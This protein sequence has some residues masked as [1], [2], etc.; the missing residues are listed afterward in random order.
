[1]TGADLFKLDTLTYEPETD[2][3]TVIGAGSAA[4]GE[5]PPDAA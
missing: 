5:Q 3:V 1:M 4:G 2:R